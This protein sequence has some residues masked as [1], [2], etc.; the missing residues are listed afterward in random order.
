[1]LSLL[2]LLYGASQ[3]SL[4]AAVG[5]GVASGVTMTALLAIISFSIDH[6]DGVDVILS[7]GGLVLL[8][9]IAKFLSTRS[10]R[11]ITDQVVAN[12]RKRIVRSLL[13]APLRT[14][15]DLG[16][17]RLL[18]ALTDDVLVLSEG[19]TLI[20]VILVDLVVVVACLLYLTM[21]SWKMALPVL[22]AIVF[23]TSIYEV[24]S[25]R[26]DRVL[27]EARDAQD[28]LFEALQGA[29]TGAKELQLNRQRR[30]SF[31][32]DELDAAADNFRRIHT[33]GFTIYA[34]A[35]SWG[36]GVFFLIIGALLFTT[37]YIDRATLVSF[38]LT[39]VYMNASIDSIF[40]AMPEVQRAET[41]FKRLRGLGLSLDVRAPDTRERAA[42]NVRS[43]EPWNGIVLEKVCHSYYHEREAKTFMLGPLTL[44][45]RP[46]KIT[47]IIGG[48]GSGKSTLVKLLVGLYPPEQGRILNGGVPVTA[49]TF[50]DYRQNFSA[51]FADYHLFRK[52]HMEASP[53]LMQR[54]EGYLK[55]L[56]LAHKVKIVDGGF[57]TIDLSSGQRKRLALLSA[58]LEDRRVYVFDEWT[59]DQDPMF[60]RLFYTEILRDLADRGKAVVC[61]THD[62]KYFSWA[63][64]RIKL[65]SGQIVTNERTVEFV[66]R[67]SNLT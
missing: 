12:L 4:A 35:T 67:M 30:E 5:L 39:I 40:T 2:R 6:R 42:P 46:G 16:S 28:S 29:A 59:A 54:A 58:Y 60:K 43:D 45:V 50:E 56:Q 23:G 47:F 27:A 32:R 13:E 65:D 41:I 49:E 18:G 1:M 31:L 14:L 51:V 9:I 25:V 63:D 44:A 55:K 17:A 61:V 33:R 52:F 48:N 37:H 24:V 22:G 20:H 36:V 34:V 7:Y 8:A 57:S 21:L 3:R 11:R 38:V 10:M 66:A 53:E 26:G 15:E 62:D 19:L 64:E